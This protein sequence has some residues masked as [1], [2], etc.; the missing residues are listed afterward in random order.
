MAFILNVPMRGIEKRLGFIK[1]NGTRRAIS[2][3]LT[4]ILILLILFAVFYLLI[5][6]VI[7][8]VITL[9]ERVKEILAEHPKIKEWLMMGQEGDDVN[10][11]ELFK[12][13]LDNF[14]A[15]IPTVVGGALSAIGS[16][17]T[18][19]FNGVIAIVFSI[20]CL[21]RKD[22]LA[23]QA[24]RL[25]YSF[26]PEKFCDNSVR[27]LQLTNRTFSYFISGQCIEACILGCLFAIAMT[28]FRM[29]YV[30]LISVLI[31]V[32][33]LIPI[34]GAFAGCVLGALFILVNN[35]MQAVWFV[36]M[37]LIIQQIENNVIYPKV[38]GKSV[39]LPGM[40][41]LVSV[42]VGGALNGVIGMLLMI[43]VVSV[44]YT[45][46][47]EITASRLAERGID[48]S[49]LEASPKKSKKK[50]KDKSKPEQ[51]ES[52]TQTESDEPAE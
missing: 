51:S 13:A 2:L 43:P 4:F 19:I 44:V 38:V 29:P 49:K 15:G 31:G 10:W 50:R 39:G 12:Q 41:V 21:A 45:L 3:T 28:I 16:V 23:V 25:A 34:V 47:R 30:P 40:W 20:Y 33:A 6:Q 14:G 18:G 22:I 48:P 37:F 1:H 8:T 35:P 11:T 9:I 46:L 5:P 17:Y 24:K 7:E 26:L 42:T 27:V 36:V 52:E 32:T